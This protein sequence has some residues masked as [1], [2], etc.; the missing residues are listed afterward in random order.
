[1]GIKM[2]SAFPSNFLKSADL[3]GREVKVVISDV[4]MEDVS[5]DG[6]MK[7]VLKFEGKNKGMVLNKTNYGRLQIGFPDFEKSDDSDELIGKEI[8]L[9]V[10]PVLFQGRTVKGLRVRVPAPE[11]DYSEGDKDPPF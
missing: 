1:M 11:P 3:G 2:G 8:V 4:D 6:E 5:G 7:P 10:E 9:C